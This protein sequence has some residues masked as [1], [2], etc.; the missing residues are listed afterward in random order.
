MMIVKVF[1][2][3][4]EVVVLVRLFQESN[5]DAILCEVDEHGERVGYGGICRLSSKGLQRI[6]CYRGQFPTDRE[7]RIVLNENK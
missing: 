7:E 3:P 6:A 1:D 2:T 5:G 4:T